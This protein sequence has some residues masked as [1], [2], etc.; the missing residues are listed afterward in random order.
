MN[1]P[2]LTPLQVAERL[3]V[4]EHTVYGWLRSGRLRGEKV[5]RLWRVPEEAVEAFLRGDEDDQYDDPL[6]P[7]EAVESESAWQAYV[8][9]EDKGEPLEV[10][11][12]ALLVTRRA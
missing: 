7:E 1:T 9:G 3:Q 6:T 10:V 11:R 4:S 8:S 2:L 12:E 5:G